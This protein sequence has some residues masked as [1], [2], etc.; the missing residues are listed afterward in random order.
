MKTSKRHSLGNLRLSHR[1]AQ[2]SEAMDIGCIHT[3]RFC[4]K[5]TPYKLCRGVRGKMPNVETYQY[6]MLSVV[7]VQVRTLDDYAA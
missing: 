3:P 6:T 7:S 4:L 1:P 5:A 2:I